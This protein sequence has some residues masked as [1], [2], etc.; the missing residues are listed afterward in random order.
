MTFAT[1]SGPPPPPQV[2]ELGG[3]EEQTSAASTEAGPTDEFGA[4]GP[5]DA[6]TEALAAT[7]DEQGVTLSDT[8]VA[9][10]LSTGDLDGLADPLDATAGGWIDSQDPYTGIAAEG[11]SDPFVGQSVDPYTG[12][13]EAGNNPNAFCGGHGVE[14]FT[15]SATSAEPDLASAYGP[16]SGSLLSSPDLLALNDSGAA[17]NANVASDAGGPSYSSSPTGSDAS[18]TDSRDFNPA[19][20]GVAS[21]TGGSFYVG[22]FTED[23]VTYDQFVDINGFTYETRVDPPA[24]DAQTPA[25]AT[26]GAPAPL[27]SPPSVT[28]VPTPPP[29]TPPP[30]PPQTSAAP[31]TPPPTPPQA[32]AAPPAPAS[33]PLAP[34]VPPADPSQT[35]QTV[36]PPGTSQP[37]PAPAPFDPMADSPIAKWLLEGT[38]TPIRDFLTNDA[39]LHAAQNAALGVSAAAAVVATGVLLLEA[40]PAALGAGAAGIQGGGL[41]SASAPLAAAGAGI[42]GSN[43]DLVTEVEEGVEGAL[44]AIGSELGSVAT[45]IEESLPGA[46]ST[47]GSVLFEARDQAAETA[48]SVVQQELSA[49]QLS[50]RFVQARFGTLLDAFAKSNIRQAISE[51]RLPNTFVTSPTVSISRGYLRAWVSAPDVWD[52]ATGR[53]W[54][55]MSS[56]EA[57]FYAHETSYLGT[58]AVG[59]LDPIGTTITEIFPLFHAGF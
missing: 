1:G 24:T 55:F 42:A 6:S 23:G 16:G 22:R 51:G 3:D 47:E 53:A 59:R 20:S 7:L 58:T 48:R 37:G 49:G 41:L 46:P 40:A 10:L 29:P 52:T 45:Q 43:P 11:V 14:P 57:S 54:D 34:L 4:L 28:A 18:A 33:P 12:S 31:P 50:L 30:T 2:P 36:A 25:G 15:G 21:D 27:A 32:S 26:P 56:T 39:N 9:Q 8:G 35:Q 19:V 13:V 44:P 38:D 17:V 5:V